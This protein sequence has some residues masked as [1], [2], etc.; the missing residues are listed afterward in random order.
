MNNEPQRA[1][2]LL[3]LDADN[4][5]RAIRTDA[6]FIID[7][8]AGAGKTELLTQRFL[9]L[10]AKVNE[11]EEIVAL[12]FTN[13]AAAEMRHRVLGSLSQAAKGEVPP[14]AHKRQTYDLSLEV[15]KRNQ[16]RQWH[17][18]EHAGR[19][20]ITT[21][22][23][24][25]GKLARQM[26]LM[27]RFGSQPRIAQDA[28]PLY[29]Q[30]AHT[31]L[32]QLE[33]GGPAAASVERVLD[34]FDNDAGRL[35]ALIVDMLEQRDQWL[36][37]SE[38]QID[39]GMAES[40]LNVLIGEELEPIYRA[41]GHA[42][43]TLQPVAQFVGS[44]I[45]SLASAG[46]KLEELSRIGALEGWKHALSAAP[47][48]LPEWRGLCELLL[49]GQGKPRSK[50]PS[51]FGLSAANG[52]HHKAFLQNF[53]ESV[54]GSVA[55]A[56]ARV[57]KFPDPHYTGPERQLIADLMEVL[58]VAR[59]A[60]WVAFQEAGVVD[61]TEM[62]QKALQALGDDDH[63]SDL[64]LSL[65]YRISHLLVDEFQDTSPTQV[66][67]LRKLTLGWQQ[68]DGRTL[69]LVGDPMQSIY[70]FRKADVGLFLKIRDAGLGD[71]R[72]TP[73]TLYRNN[74]SHQE[75]VEW[76]N[77]VF[78]A[79]FADQD[80]FRRGAV[81]FAQAQATRGTHGLAGVT[82]HPVVEMQGGSG[83]FDD[84][85]LDPADEQEALAV[86]NIVRQAQADDPNGTVAVLVK[87]RTHLVSIVKA[88][89][90][91]QPSLPFQ[92]VEIEVLEQRQWIQDLLSLTHALLHRGERIHWLA[93][94]RA[95]WCGL[96][97][98]DLHRLVG[99]DHTSAVWA[100]MQDPVRCRRLTPDGQQRL[101]HVREVFEE[102]FAFQG[103]QRLRRWVEGTWHN[104][105]GPL[106]LHSVSD[107][108]D[109]KAYFEVLDRLD[110]QGSLDLGR[111][112]VE[113][114]KLYAAPDPAAGRGLQIM[115]VH[116]SKG[117]E[118][119]T[120]IL[121]GLHKR[122]KSEDPKLLLWDEVMV[123]DEQEH[124]ILA[125]WPHGIS[126]DD[127]SP[128]KYGFIKQ[129]ESERTKNELQRLLYV[130]VT[131]TKRHLHLLG[132]AS[133]DP[134]M[135]IGPLK[136]PSA[137]SLLGLLWGEGRR[138]FE[139]AYAR[140]QDANAPTPT[141][142][143]S[144]GPKATVPEDEAT[145]WSP[146]NFNHRLVRLK[147]AERPKALRACMPPN[148]ATGAAIAHESQG[149]A[150]P[151]SE[152][153]G[154][155]AADIGTLVH[156]YLEIIATDGLDTWSPE[157]LHTLKGPVQ[158]WLRQQG[159]SSQV[160]PAGAAEVVAHLTTTLNSEDGRRVLGAHEEAE[161]ESAFTTS[162]DGK[163]ETHIVDRT[164]VDNGVRW[165]VDY[166]TTRHADD[167]AIV[168]SRHKEQ[169]FRYGHLYGGGNVKLAVFLTRT[170]KLV[171]ME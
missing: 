42:W 116:K 9:A 159:H 98:E 113:V 94:L 152:D 171:C 13:K 99:D 109:A 145:R 35:H 108:L 50:F 140:L 160:A 73:L 43:N 142:Q 151:N 12:T 64:Q 89:R 2:D 46:E 63:P 86:V 24:L 52:R 68:G 97:L 28:G 112:K 155:L 29:R 169:L 120:V 106:C 70:R 105:A 93:T 77:R 137:S 61:F 44:H 167:E 87:A 48:H 37:H 164:F 81:K 65:D 18:L 144:A 79:V 10:L 67:L 47:G 90:A 154:Q 170:G 127:D 59:G 118:F 8:P 56:L 23:A 139:Q 66:E 36:R 30:A 135:E 166:K 55:S 17:L 34:H 69:F 38:Q 111:L 7:A 32:Q 16:E 62:A 3:A 117:L 91:Q 84:D 121:P 19:L 20:N 45:R 6:S 136:A 57:R 100:L 143:A 110:E 165:V 161:C 80:N 71:I 123:E 25:C 33:A 11:P 26:P 78:P 149:A 95:P 75:I 51:T 132:C 153:T 115:T 31:T 122:P 125:P 58:N 163:I 158:R 39:L 148:D 126:S 22:D 157:R 133:L 107:G 21:L 72:P 102:A 150:T 96:V 60:L 15:L 53:L 131:R 147:V 14:E 40:A 27:S 124:L 103:Q 128:S 92:A 88:L 146:E 41:L 134:K 104:L 1:Q 156:K 129:F 119:D 168:L 82:W 49:T 4:R 74:R 83:D 141:A 130:A 101:G 5:L 114:A 76:G 85:D 138:H 162:K 54:N